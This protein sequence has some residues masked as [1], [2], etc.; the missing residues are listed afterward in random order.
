MLLHPKEKRPS[1][2]PVTD[3]GLSK[4][5]RGAIMV[6]VSQNPCL[7]KDARR[8][9]KQD[10]SKRRPQC[11][12]P[13]CS[14]LHGCPVL[15]STGVRQ[16]CPNVTGLYR[17]SRFRRLDL[18]CCSW[19]CSVPLRLPFVLSRSVA[20][21]YLGLRFAP[22]TN[23]GGGGGGGGCKTT[24]VVMSHNPILIVMFCESAVDW[25]VVK[26]RRLDSSQSIE[27][28]TT[29]KSGYKYREFVGTTSA[30]K[31]LF[32]SLLIQHLTG[33]LALSNSNH[34]LLH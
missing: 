3:F 18:T 21:L 31:L 16:G 34:T 22:Y 10:A 17:K 2:S 13:L 32:P 6:G 11:E 28:G 5:L 20:L 1:K 15:G 24:V 29:T 23:S 9:V 33:V 8:R 25:K 12:R 26:S 14:S 19:L 27:Y 30:S 4:T 7:W